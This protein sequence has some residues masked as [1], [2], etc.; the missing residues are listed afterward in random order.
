M[1]ESLNQCEGRGI[2]NNGTTKTFHISRH[3][4]RH[5][6]LKLESVD[7]DGAYLVKKV[8]LTNLRQLETVTKPISWNS[9][10]ESVESSII[11]SPIIKRLAF[12]CVEVRNTLSKFFMNCLMSFQY[13]RKMHVTTNCSLHPQPIAPET[14]LH[15]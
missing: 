13:N 3:K 6:S 2:S 5:Y 10:H 12:F 7:Q 14:C 1:K 15:C 8:L 4:G 9:I 11:L